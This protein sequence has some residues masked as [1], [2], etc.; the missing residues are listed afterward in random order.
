MNKNFHEWFMAPQMD[1]AHR[2]L[3]EPRNTQNN[4]EEDLF[5]FL[6]LPC[7]PWLKNYSAFITHISTL[8]AGGVSVF[9]DQVSLI[10]EKWK[11]KPEKRL[12]EIQ[13]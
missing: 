6:C 3:I 4:T 10:S 5:Y 2:F 11:L 13:R 8:A 9:T 1:T 12:K 7:V